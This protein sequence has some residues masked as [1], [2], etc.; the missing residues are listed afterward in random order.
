MLLPES[1]QVLVISLPSSIGRR[2]KVAAE[3]AKV[4]IKWSFL[5]AIDGATLRLNDV[6]AY[7]P[8]KVKRLLGFELTNRELGCYFSHLKAWQFCVDKNIPTVILED[9]FVLLPHFEKVL[10]YLVNTYKQWEIV[11]LQA[12]ANSAYSVVQDAGDFKIIKNEQDPL[13]ATA[14][15]VNPISANRLIDQ[16]SEV[17]EPVD[18]FIEHFEKHGLTMLAVSKYPVTVV[19]ATGATSTINDRPERMS[20]KGISKLKRSIFRVI[21]RS[22]S[23]NPWFPK[24][25]IK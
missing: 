3:M 16:S 19:D 14:Y 20:I 22:F 17:F 2:K 1:V 12:L 15:M 7:K 6:K 10:N 11:R 8:Q 24:L 5:E 25:T 23:K 13:G 18:H 9:D 4:Q 21:D